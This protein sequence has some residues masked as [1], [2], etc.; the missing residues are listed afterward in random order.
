LSDLI[1]LSFKTTDE[2]IYHK[3]MILVGVLFLVQVKTQ[4]QRWCLIFALICNFELLKI[5]VTIFAALLVANRVE[6]IKLCLEEKG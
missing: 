3:K 1:N 5:F 4:N 6:N 2:N